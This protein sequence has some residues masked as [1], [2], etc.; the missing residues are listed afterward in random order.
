MTTKDPHNIQIGDLIHAMAASEPCLFN[1]SSE[2]LM[3]VVAGT[4]VIIPLNTRQLRIN[5]RMFAI[6]RW[7]GALQ[8]K[9]EVELFGHNLY[10]TSIYV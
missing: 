1:N 10:T 7:H 8:A 3:P 5:E 2:N 9:F 4:S 6:S